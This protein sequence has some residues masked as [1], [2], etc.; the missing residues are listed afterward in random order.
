MN[1]LIPVDDLARLLNHAGERW[2]AMDHEDRLAFCRCA[3]KFAAA[4][5]EKGTPHMTD[6]GQRKI[7]VIKVWRAHAGLG[8]KEAKEAVE[9]CPV[10]L[11]GPDAS[12]RQVADLDAFARALRQA[13][14]TVKMMLGIPTDIA[15]AEGVADGLGEAYGLLADLD[16]PASDPPAE[17]ADSRVRASIEAH[18]A[19]RTMKKMVPAE[20]AEEVVEVP[21]WWV[22][23]F[24][25]TGPRM[26]F[27]GSVYGGEMA[28]RTYLDV[29]CEGVVWDVHTRGKLTVRVPRRYLEPPAP[30]DLGAVDAEG[31]E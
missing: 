21:V 28:D 15:R 19:G 18:V 14:A 13:G 16:R 17:D 27:I 20:G 9:S 10:S 8:L 29:V 25:D 7:E 2:A 6:F 30:I 1:A 31:E 3:G 23:G 12:G 11:A 5:R 24:G 26:E 4:E 22:S